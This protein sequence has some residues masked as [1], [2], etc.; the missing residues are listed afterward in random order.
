MPAALPLII[1]GVSLTYLATLIV[2]WV[3]SRRGRTPSGAAGIAIIVAVAVLGVLP[4]EILS[5]IWIGLLQRHAEVT[6]NLFILVPTPIIAVMV[7]IQALLL[8]RI[9]RNRPLILSAIYLG[10]FAAAY[11]FWL[12]RLFNPPAD[13]VRYVLVILLCGAVVVGLIWRLVWQRPT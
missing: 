4:T 5:I 11:A 3:R 12:S 9:Y 6:A 7:A 8:S 13:I 1:L 2:F 10:V